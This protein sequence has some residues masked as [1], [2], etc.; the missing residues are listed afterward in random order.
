MT[1]KRKMTERRKE[2]EAQAKKLYDQYQANQKA[3]KGEK[4]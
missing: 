4:K 1:E 2:L 3:K